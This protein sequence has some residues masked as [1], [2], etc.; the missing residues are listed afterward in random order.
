MLRARIATLSLLL[1]LAA[2]ALPA[3]SAAA[4]AEERSYAELVTFFQEWREFAAPPV[5][6][7]VPDY[8]REAMAAQYRAL[9]AWRERLAAFDTSGWPVEQQI[10]HRLV[11]AEIDGLDFDHRVR[12]PWA[13]DPAFYVMLFAAQS[14]VPAHE[15]PVIHGWIDTWTYDYPL[16]ASDAAE[17]AGRIGV[18][19]PVLEQARANLVGPGRDLWRMSIG[20]LRGQANDLRAFGERVAGVSAELDRVLTG[21]TAATERF[22]EWLEAELVFKNGWS[23]VGRDNYSWRH[24]NVEL[25]PYDWDEVLALMQREL[26]RAHAALRLEE[27]RNRALPELGRFE[28]A[29][30]YDR[31]LAAAVDEYMEFLDE[32]EIVSLRDWMAPALLERV[33]SFSEP[34]RADG[35]RGFFSEV[36]YR[37]GLVMRTHGYHWF[38]LARMEY[39]PH[40]SP[41]RRV[42]ALFN[43]YAARSEGMATGVEEMFMHAG[44]FDDRPRARE[45]VWI[46]LAQRAARAIGGLMMHANEWTMQEAVDF[47][48]EWTP[49]GWLPADGAT[50]WGEQHLYLRQPGYGTSYLIGKIQIEQL[51]AERAT[52]L[53]EEFSI[54][55][56]FDE[57]DATGVIPLSMARWQMTGLRGAALDR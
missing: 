3:G 34:Q 29:D 32:E 38:D 48:A 16:S 51:L 11:E 33:G 36:Q 47:A 5:R 57:L 49:R 53:G 20:S 43:V 55:R 31:A 42:P 25:V 28:S 41:I 19:A 50:V 14:D 46:L 35:L 30:E 22:V 13:N 37:D 56:F 18:I 15:G 21:A 44:L 40:E 8:G 9:P 17:L 12:K 23:G 26:W 6:D 4:P 27:N 7:G 45:L 52:Q 24:R 39:E 54:R 10:D 2:A 1:L